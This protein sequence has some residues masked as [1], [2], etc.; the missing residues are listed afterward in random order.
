MNIITRRACVPF[1]L[2][3][4]WAA[5]GAPSSEAASEEGA[6]CEAEGQLV[7]SVRGS[8]IPVFALDEGDKIGARMDPIDKTEI[9]A[10]SPRIL[11]CP[12]GAHYAIDWNGQQVAILRALVRIDKQRSLPPCSKVAIASIDEK[13]RAAPGMSDP[14]CKPE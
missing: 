3:A 6:K 14:A 8:R 13:A 10:A 5:S 2:L 12:T 11:G 4:I 1:Y 9:E 7:E